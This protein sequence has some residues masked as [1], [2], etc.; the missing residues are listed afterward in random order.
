MPEGVPDPSLVKEAQ[1]ITGALLWVATRSRPDISYAVSRMGQQATRTPRLSISIGHQVLQYLNSTLRFGIE[2]Q[3]EGGP[4]FS[5]HGLLAVPRRDQVI[6]VYSD[7]SHAPCGG[8]SVQSFMIVWRGSPLVWE[9]T[10]QSFTTLSSAE[11][12]LV[13]MSHAIQ[14][15]ESVQPL[16]DELLSMDSIVALLADNSAAIRAFDSAP[17]G[18]RSRHLRMRAIA[19]R[20]K[21][22]TNQLTVSH[23]PGEYQVADVGTKPLPRGRIFSTVGPSRHKGPDGSG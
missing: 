21:I 23:L 18:W 9:S 19:G 10:R 20:E 15:S 1:G 16:I 12:E 6:E 11:A 2:Y 8:R 3:F 13:G 5:G 4:Y 22:E 7:A 14:M 17:S